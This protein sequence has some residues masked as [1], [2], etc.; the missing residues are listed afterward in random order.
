MLL[1]AC[2][3]SPSPTMWGARH[4]EVSLAGRAYTVWWTDT[5]FEVVRHGWAGPG[6]HRDIRA[7]MLALVPQVTQCRVGTARGDS[8]EIHGTLVC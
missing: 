3:A 8:G 1:A 7:A 6:T 5:K 4:A 2:A